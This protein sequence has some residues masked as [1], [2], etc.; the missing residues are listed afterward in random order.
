MNLLHPISSIMTRNLYTLES[1]DSIEDAGK[2]F[3]EKR[4]HHIPIVDSGK[5]VGIVSKSDYLFFRK[6]FDD[7]SSETEK[8]R[9][10]NASVSEIMTKGIAKMEPDDRINVALEIFKKNILHAIPVV[11][12]ERL[13]GIVTTHDIISKLAEDNEAH[14]EYEKV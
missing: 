14:S 8:T 9:V 3:K 7:A 5:L 4:I 11:K 1:F 6:G 13:V 10:F 2:L 12:N